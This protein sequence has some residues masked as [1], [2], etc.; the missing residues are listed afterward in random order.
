MTPTAATVDTATAA[1][2]QDTPAAAPGTPTP[3]LVRKSTTARSAIAPS[4]AAYSMNGDLTAVQDGAGPITTPAQYD[5]QT[6]L[7][8]WAAQLDALMAA[9]LTSNNGWLKFPVTFLNQFFKPSIVV[10]RLSY[11]LNGLATLM[12]QFVPPFKMVDGAPSTITQASVTAAVL[13]GAIVLFN[14]SQTVDIQHWIEEAV[15][16]AGALQD[17]AANPVINGLTANDMDG[18]V[19]AARAAFLAPKTVLDMTIDLGKAP[20][21]VSLAMY[22]VV[23]AIFRRFA[24]VA[25]DH[26][27]V[28]TDMQQTSQHLPGASGTTVSGYVQFYD[29]DGDPITSYGFTEPNDSRFT[30]TVVDGTNGRMNWTVWDWNPLGPSTP[31]TLTFTLTVLAQGDGQISVSKPYMP[32]GNETQK[33]VTVTVYYN[34]AIGTMTNTV[35]STS[36][37]GVVRGVVSSPTNPD[38]PTTYSLNGAS[39][40]SAYTANGG[41]VKLNSATGAYVYT[42]N[43]ASS[44][45]TDSFQLTS[46]DSFGHTYTTSVTVPVSSASPVTTFNTRTGTVT[47]SLAIPTGGADVGL[48]NY[49]LGTGPDPARGAVTVNADGTFVYTRSSTA[50]SQPTTDS[51][52]ILGTDSSGKTVTVA[53]V[54]VNATLGNSAPVGTGLTTDSPVG[55]PTYNALGGPRDEQHT[56]GTLHATDA[57]GDPVTFAAGTYTTAQGGSVAV[58]ANGTFTYDKNVF[59]PL[60]I[61]NSYWHTHAVDGDPGD[62]F[63]INVTDSYGATTAV[64]YSVP[65]AKLNAPP[66]VDSG[67]INNKTTSGMGVVRGNIAGSDGDGDGLT[68]SMIG[69]TGGSVYSA[70]GGIVKINS[71]GTFTYTPKVGVTSDSFQV[72]V[73]DGHGGTTQATVNL[74]GLTTPSPTT[75]VNT[76][77]PGK[78]TG[79]L[80]VPASESGL[81]TYSLGTGPSKGAVTVNADGTYSYTRTAGLGHTTTPKDSF[82]IVA[83]EIGTGK[84]VTI[85]T[86]AV[87]PTVSNVA[88][89]GNGV[90]TDSPVGA[91][92]YNVW[93]GPSDEQHTT[94]TLHATDAD[95][96]AVT[97]TAGTYG[98]TQ[99]GSITVNADGTFTYDNSKSALAGIH[100]SYWHTHAADGDPGDTFTINVSDGFGGTTAV[101]YGVPI[102]KLNAA[103]TLSTTV[104]G[105][106][107]STLG[108]VRGTVSGDDGDND[109]LTYSLV[110]ATGGSVYSAN[111]GIVTMSGNSFTYVPKV[112]V[113]SDTFQVQVNDGHGGTATQ[114][115]SLA[116]LSTPSPTTNID[117]SVLGV[118]TGRL[119]VP[120]SAPTNDAGLGLTYGGGGT[121]SKGSVVVNSDGTFT[122]TRNSALGH[123]QALADTF[124]VTA[125]LGGKTVTIATITVTPTID[126]AV[127]VAGTATVT[128]S[129]LTSSGSNRTQTTS[130]TLTATDANGDTV[131]FSPVTNQATADGGTI[132]ISANGTYTYTI[133]KPVSYFHDAAVIGASGSAITDTFTVVA[134]DGFKGTPTLTYS[135]LTEKQNVVPTTSSSISGADTLGVVR[136]SVTGIDGDSGETFT[137]TLVGG[138]PASGSAVSYITT[139]GGLV[140]MTGANTFAYVPKVGVTSDSFQIKVDDGHGGSATQTVSLTG[141]TTP[142]PTTGVAKPSKGIQ[143]GTISIPATTDT[144]DLGLT[145]SIAGNGSMGTATLTNTG[146]VYTYTYTRTDNGTDTLSTVTTDSFTIRATDASGKTVTVATINVA[147][148]SYANSA[149]VLVVNGVTGTGTTASTTMS[150]PGSYNTSTYTQ[151]LTG[152]TITASDADGDALKVNN[153][154]DGTGTAVALTA[155]ATISTRNGGTVTV[156]ANG[157]LSYSITKT[158]AEVKTYY[159]GAAKYGA[160]GDAV[161]DWFNV[162]VTDGNGGTSTVKVTVPIWAINSAPVITYERYDIATV[163][164]VRATDADTD[165]IPNTANPATGN[166]GYVITTSTGSTRDFTVGSLSSGG[167]ITQLSSGPWPHTIK[168]YDGYYFVVNGVVTGQLAYG[169]MRWNKNSAGVALVVD[170]LTG[171]S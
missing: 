82:T 105:K 157:T 57:D 171:S 54:N 52:T 118:V 62:T 168:V 116:G 170:P 42:P 21:P 109:S 107:T 66:T 91:P 22:V 56:T 51:F 45:T 106:T 20:N 144:T 104:G 87:T 153:K 39:G 94:G 12:D 166:A 75:N 47:G 67:T 77:T 29:A 53:M 32:N 43:R 86:I 92:T 61:H 99:G 108:V 19:G 78:V 3:G 103:P 24:D 68:Y 97:F 96:D 167:N 163:Y 13:A 55:A 120:S 145:Y 8:A 119:N 127:P 136:G 125:T 117:T 123:S 140:I 84:T 111:G 158:S 48:M 165:S 88:P 60:G 26:Q 150:A 46:T 100:Q 90:T 102:A 162:I 155:G 65:I 16:L 33:T 35:N 4:A 30:V 15:S 25:T 129:A 89:V 93:G 7:D 151:T 141:L 1:P 132:T 85:A 115:I 37:L 34:Q 28:V 121:T 131:T 149:P 23:V 49:S 44:A 5:I 164:G 10:D 147:P 40:G 2:A 64:T 110:G 113:T 146:G 38:N 161:A 14:T 126:N 124:T 59:A 154:Y 6:T 159:H 114:T 156:N 11:G 70:N 139:N 169:G 81:Y 138:S 142:S 83:T 112:G 122:Y 98:T 27:P 72:L 137:Y 134:N 36:G 133:T 135:I 79:Q 17:I 76:G 58:T 80:G 18:V 9:P 71:N 143:T 101:T 95:G 73:N 148:T 63:T 74:T 152:I 130:G 31:K 50:G 128:S 41:I 69:A 160:S